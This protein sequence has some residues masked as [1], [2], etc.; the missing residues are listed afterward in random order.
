MSYM[1]P[2]I[3]MNANGWVPTVYVRY[4]H[5]SKLPFVSLLDFLRSKL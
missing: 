1:S 3:Y 2:A 4:I 5:K